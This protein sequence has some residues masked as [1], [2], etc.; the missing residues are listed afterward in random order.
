MID[1]AT[2]KGTASRRTGLQLWR[3]PC[4]D[5]RGYIEG[6]AVRCGPCGYR[7]FPRHDR[8]GYIEGR[9]IGSRSRA[10]AGCFPV[11]VDGAKLKI[12]YSHIAS[13]ASCGLPIRYSWGY[14]DV[15]TL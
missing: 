15:H 9:S 5:R 10:A 12:I 11:M 14:I 8:R 2:L 13:A 7:R 1:G 6:P 3:F 4:H